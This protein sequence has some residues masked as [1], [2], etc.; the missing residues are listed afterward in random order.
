MIVEAR[1]WKIAPAGLDILAQA[2][3]VSM[4]GLEADLRDD[5]VYEDG[6]LRLAREL[7]GRTAKPIF[8]Y[9]SFDQ[10]NNRRSGGDLADRGVP[11]LNG[12]ENTLAAIRSFQR[13]ADARREAAQP[14]PCVP[15]APD[16]PP[17]FDEV[18]SLTLLSRCGVPAARSRV[19]ATANTVIR[20]AEEIGY[21]L[22]LKTAAAGIVHKSD[23]GVSASEE[24]DT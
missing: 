14:L 15:P 4:L 1:T 10:A 16:V 13:W 12:A 2:P 18:S 23:L 22:V 3:E 20:A 11:V 24:V 7:A 9:T 5:Y 8:L 21:P 19:C 17:D 6:L